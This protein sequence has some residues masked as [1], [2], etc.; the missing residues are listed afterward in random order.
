MRRVRTGR[1]P[2]QREAIAYIFNEAE[3]LET[4]R[5]DPQRYIYRSYWEGAARRAEELGYTLDVFNAREFHGG[6]LA[7]ILRSRG[8]RGV[9]I[10]PWNQRKPPPALDWERLSPVLIGYSERLPP[11]HRAVSHH[12]HTAAL[13]V[14][15]LHARGFRRIG[16]ALPRKTGILTQHKLL[17]GY[18]ATRHNFARQAAIR[19]FIPP[20][21]RFTEANFMRWL[22]REA[23][24]AVL[25]VHAMVK[26]CLDTPGRP[27]FV[28][29]DL[30]PPGKRRDGVTGVDTQP[31][32]L[33]AA[34]FEMVA[35]QLERNETGLPDNPK[36][37]LVETVWVGADNET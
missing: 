30:P 34:A 33:G 31:E 16:L 5:A 7:D 32:K 20:L 13:A 9:V 3:S 15:R 4:L 8:I 27:P 22:E 6:R 14:D 2:E 29:L 23:P 25:G 36:T 10:N 24:D 28:S 26:D 17:G 21:A 18:L 11:M 1:E 35:D 37:T 12:F 19:P